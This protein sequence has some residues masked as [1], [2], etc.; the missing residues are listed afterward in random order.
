MERTGIPYPKG[1]SGFVPEEGR[2]ATIYFDHWYGEVRKK[3]GKKQADQAFDLLGRFTK[4]ITTCAPV[5]II[6]SILGWF[7]LSESKDVCDLRLEMFDQVMDP[8][9]DARG[10][11]KE[12]IRKWDQNPS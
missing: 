4:S 2:I 9:S 5:E 3:F 7:L 11:M 10:L 8:I 12:L 1:V 6:T